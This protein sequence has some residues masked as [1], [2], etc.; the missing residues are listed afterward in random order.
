MSWW[1]AV[2]SAIGTGAGQWHANTTN[3]KIAKKQM[4]FQERMSNT[5]VQRR[6]EDMRLAGINPLL[7]GQHE[8]SSPAGAGATMQNALG[9]GITSAMQAMQLKAGLKKVNAEVKNIEAGTAKTKATTDIMGPAST[10]MKEV[11]SGIQQLM[12]QESGGSVVKE[13]LG[14]ITG[15]KKFGSPESSQKNAEILMGKERG[16]AYHQ[17]RL[18]AGEARIRN[19]LRQAESQLRLYKNEDSTY[20]KRKIEK[21]IRDLKLT[22]SMYR[23]PGQ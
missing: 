1:E 6:M 19:E 21:K 15:V 22:L 23:K 7:A 17:S 5:A 2:G 13:M 18:N 3:W 8:A 9:Q 10:L 4:A 16:T 12:G 11:T 14:A 20:S